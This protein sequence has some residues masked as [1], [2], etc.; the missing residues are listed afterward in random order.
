M[1]VLFSFSAGQR[2][3]TDIHCVNDA[4]LM[5]HRL[6]LVIH[7][8]ALCSPPLFLGVFE[9]EGGGGQEEERGEMRPL[10]TCIIS[11]CLA[12]TF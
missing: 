2:C 1:I 4:Y 5:L 6:R 8:Y 3:Q 11:F 10:C 12:C 9:A 7:S